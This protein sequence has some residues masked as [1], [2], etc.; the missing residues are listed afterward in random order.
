MINTERKWVELPAISLTADGAENGK[1]TVTDTAY[2]K[3]KMK[4]TLQSDTL[5]PTQFEIKQVLSRTEMVLGPVG[6]KHHA[7]SD[8]TEFL[9]TDNSVLKAN[10]QDRPS[11][12]PVD[13]ER[14]VY[15]EEPTM[16][17]RVVPV[18]KY[19]EMNSPDSPLYAQLAD[20]SVNIGTVNA[21]LEVQLSHRDN[22]PDAGDI[23][24]SV[25]VG[26]GVEIIQV[27]PDGSINTVIKDTF[28][29]TP[30][31]YRE[32]NAFTNISETT[33]ATFTASAVNSRMI[34]IWGEAQTFGS[35]KVYRDTVSPANLVVWKRTSPMKRT[36]EI[37][38]D[39][40]EELAAINDKLIITFQAD[41]YRSFLL[42]A[43]ATTFVRIE[44]S[45]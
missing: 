21:E 43:S 45:Y 16:A 2:Y 9:L 22:Y 27:N 29:G 37:K 6:S 39:Q 25:Q 36:C 23:A 12:P 15:E 10:T 8:L 14:A 20:G 30:I 1:I 33:V 19:G 13:Y 18:N 34:K 42:G 3:V 31:I 32:S 5:Q 11:I 28:S 24:D 38:L 17:K 4:V 44:G 35:W 40:P 7:T 26:D 41:R